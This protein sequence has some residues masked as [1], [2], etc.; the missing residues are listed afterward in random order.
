MRYQVYDSE[1]RFVA[2]T[3]SEMM[4]R[5]IRE[6]VR[7]EDEQRRLRN[8]R[9]RG[10]EIPTRLRGDGLPEGDVPVSHFP[11]GQRSG[12]AGGH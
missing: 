5:D 8:L 10:H 11:A 4:A 1:G 3:V 9:L 12:Q 7:R 6:W 2:E